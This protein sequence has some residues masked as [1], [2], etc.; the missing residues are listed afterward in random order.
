MRI[1][2][3][4]AALGLMLAG[5]S[6][7]AWAD[8]KSHLAAAEEFLRAANTEQTMLATIDQMLAV[9]LKANPQ[10]EPVKD[11]MKNFFAKHLSYSALKDDLIKVYMAEFTEA[12]M[13]EIAAFYRT[14]TG[15]KTI[16]KMPVLMQKGAELGMKRVQD[17]LAELK[18][19]IEKALKKEPDNPRR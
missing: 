10:L 7:A 3:S 13:K 19:R 11:V 12:E 2:M 6:W 1:C 18:Q 14:P 15:K 5:A 16:E 17:N 9:Q 4:L 8:E